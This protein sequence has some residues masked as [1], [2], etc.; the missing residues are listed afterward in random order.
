[1]GHAAEQDKTGQTLKQTES[2]EREGPV[3][4][5]LFGGGTGESGYGKKGIEGFGVT[6]GKLRERR[7]ISTGKFCSIATF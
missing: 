6:L 1:V 3:F 5:G 7:A 4:Q 2:Q